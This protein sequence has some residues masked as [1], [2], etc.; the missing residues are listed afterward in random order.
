MTGKAQ[1]VPTRR[2]SEID[3]R[4]LGSENSWLVGTG[5]RVCLRSRYK[6]F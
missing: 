2:V 4:R 1:H 5:E 3:S 6:T